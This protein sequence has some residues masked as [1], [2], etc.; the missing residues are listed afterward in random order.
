MFS[1]LGIPVF[2]ADKEAKRLMEENAQL[3]VKIVDLLGSEAF[4][5]NGKLNRSFIAEKVFAEPETLAALNAL[6]HPVVIE[7]G[8]Q[9]HLQFSDV[10]FTLKEAALLIESGSYRQ[11]DAIIVVTA[12]EALRLDRVVKRDGVSPQKVMERIKNQLS[13]KEML[14]HADFIIVNDGQ[15][16]LGPQVMEVYRRLAAISAKS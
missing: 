7:A 1:S 8:D 14:K 11:L 3:K 13:E 16:Q 4:D 12:P 5:K 10:P 15:T 9:W 2:N 6:V